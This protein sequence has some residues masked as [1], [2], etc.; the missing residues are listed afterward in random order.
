MSEEMNGKERVLES[1]SRFIREMADHIYHG[2]EKWSSILEIVGEGGGGSTGTKQVKTGI[3]MQGKINFQQLD[4]G[5]SV[6]I[7]LE[8][9]GSPLP[10]LQ[11]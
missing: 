4:G 7:C 11:N 8:Q 1:Y 5:G 6:L 9:G 3:L 2:M 10:K